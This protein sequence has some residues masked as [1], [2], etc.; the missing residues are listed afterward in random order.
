[1]DSQVIVG[2]CA[3]QNL[4]VPTIGV[5]RPPDSK[6]PITITITITIT[7]HV[8]MSPPNKA[9]TGSYCLPFVLYVPY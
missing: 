3:G 8:E 5:V 2:F 1:M 6:P 7:V 4:S 9:T